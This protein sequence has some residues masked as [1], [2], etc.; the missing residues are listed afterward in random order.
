MMKGRFPRTTHGGVSGAN[1]EME[2]SM[3]IQVNTDRNVEGSAGLTEQVEVAVDAALG[4][5]GER[6]T[7]IEVHLSDDNSKAK[8]REGDMRCVM[9]ARPAGLQP[10]T[11]SHLG[12]T[13]KQAL[14]GAAS[15]LEKTL[16]RTFEKREP[17]RGHATKNEDDAS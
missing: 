8:S 7:R 11:V 2:S 5:F 17:P 3:Q 12:D 16:K 13:L 14:E 6:I 15:K 9:E 10:I 1:R 4:R